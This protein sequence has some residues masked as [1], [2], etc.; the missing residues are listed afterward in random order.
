M[1][2]LDVWQ[3]I[4]SAIKMNKLRTFLT[5]FSV[6]WGIF[7][8]II[9]LS[10]GNGLKNGFMQNMGSVV[11]TIDMWGG[12][13][14]IPHAGLPQGRRIVFNNKDI[15]F[16][17]NMPN[18]ANV[19][20]DLWTSATA[21]V[22]S[23]FSPV[24]VR[25]VYPSVKVSNDLITAQGRF[26]NDM[27]MRGFRK[28]AL[29][30]ATI[31]QNLFKGKDCIGE[32]IKLADAMFKVVGV[33]EERRSWRNDNV[34]YIPFTT[35]QRMFGDGWGINSLQF[36]VDGLTTRDANEQFN[37]ELRRKFALRHH[38]HPDDKRAIGIW[39]QMESYLQ[40][41]SIFNGISMFMW[42]IGIGTLLAGVVGVSNIMLITVRERTREFGIRKALGAK[43]LSVIKL[44]LLESI[45][46]TA[47]FGYAGM[48]LGI[49]LTEGI[50][51][52]MGSGG[53]NTIFTNP[54]VDL[55]V[56]LLST[57]ALVIAGVMA[58][59]FPARKAIKITAV[60]A[61]RAE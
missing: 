6:A 42:I 28:V 29:I 25:G 23:E 24:Q 14:S 46:I 56:A 30:D 36:T 1:F 26:I 38:S 31:K 33:Y 12:R 37:A 27:D 52:L 45:A 2:D 53:G 35:H 21:T 47:L 13:I 20:A 18:L 15:T 10:A 9:L 16:T 40:V 11:N 3:E 51:A 55:K 50:S 22:G 54:T 61:M 34:I 5:G 32:Y 43:P 39:N 44:I 19:G 41:V 59:Y 49:G 60:E 7:M 48:V 8:L 58:G 17:E 57:L 4:V